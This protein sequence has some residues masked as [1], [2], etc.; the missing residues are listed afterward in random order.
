[1]IEQFKIDNVIYSDVEFISLKYEEIT[2]AAPSSK[3]TRTEGMNL[4]DNSVMFIPN[5]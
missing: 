3:L 2:G 4:L 1:M 5:S